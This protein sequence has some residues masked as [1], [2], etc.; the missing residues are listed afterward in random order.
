[1]IEVVGIAIVENNRLLVSK[2]LSSRGKYTLVGG[3]V[4]ATDSS[5]KDAAIREMKEELGE[6]VIAS[7]EELE[8]ILDFQEHATSDPNK[9]IHMHIFL[10]HGKLKQ[11]I[12]H[13]EIIEYHWFS[14][15]ED[16]SILSDS[17]SKHLLPY[18]EKEKILTKE[19][20]TF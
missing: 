8:E 20:R 1:M 2:S 19:R 4:E 5:L 6:E 16:S 18:F 7:K 10:Y 12:P 15:K 11:A 9:M 17:I 14:L 13:C 3:K